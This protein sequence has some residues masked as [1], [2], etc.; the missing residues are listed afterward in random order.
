MRYNYETGMV[1]PDIFLS[2]D[3]VDNQHSSSDK[4]IE[5]CYRHPDGT[6]E[7]KYR[8]LEGSLDCELFKFQIEEMM[9][10]FGNECL[11]YW[12]EAEDNS[13]TK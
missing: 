2:I 5:F 1:T 7:V 4:M 9:E 3:P 11:Y 6:V 8:R 12:R 13:I 10:K